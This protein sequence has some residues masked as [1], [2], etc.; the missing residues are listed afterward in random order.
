MLQ[1]IIEQNIDDPNGNPHGGS[2]TGVGIDIRWQAGPL[3][4]GENRIEPN[5]AFVEGVIQAAIG[6]MEYYQSSRFACAENAEALVHLK[7]ALAALESRTK[8]REVREVEGTH[9]A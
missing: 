4:R 5:G 6:R 7:A 9:E 1:E 2:V 8:S 3:G